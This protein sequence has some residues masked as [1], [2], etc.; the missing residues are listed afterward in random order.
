MQRSIVPDDSGIPSQFGSG[1]LRLTRRCRGIDKYIASG[2]GLSVDEVHC[3]S[4]LLLDHPSSVKRLG[5]LIS[6]TSTR[7]SKI[8]RDLENAS[9]VS[10]TSDEIDRRKALVRLT[11]AGERIALRITVLYAEFGNEILAHSRSEMI[12]DFSWLLRIVGQK[13]QEHQ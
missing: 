2:I 9:Y 11:D 4:A 10:R 3:L 5:E 7:V 13:K 12:D 1:L 6:V 8:L